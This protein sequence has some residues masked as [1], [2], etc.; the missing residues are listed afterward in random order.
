MGRTVVVAGFKHMH[1][2]VTADPRPEPINPVIQISNY[3]SLCKQTIDFESL[4]RPPLL[5]STKALEILIVG[6]R[7]PK[8]PLKGASLI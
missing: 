6:T 2:A 3:P 1:A 4:M 5:Y 8:S 7:H